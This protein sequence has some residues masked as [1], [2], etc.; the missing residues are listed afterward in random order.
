MITEL[1]CDFVL[2]QIIMDESGMQQ[3]PRDFKRDDY[4]VILVELQVG[5]PTFRNLTYSTLICQ[6]DRK[7]IIMVP[8][9]QFL[10]WYLV[11]VFAGIKNVD[12]FDVL[13]TNKIVHGL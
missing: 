1:G 8:L 3:Y 4:D 2:E 5:P 10:K 7:C 11:F 13:C 6:S 12:N 9:F